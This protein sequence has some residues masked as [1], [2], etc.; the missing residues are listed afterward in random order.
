MKINQ[1]KSKVILFNPCKSI[2]FMTQINLENYGLE[3]FE[4][5]LLLGLVLRSEMDHQHGLY[6]KQGKLETL[7]TQKG[8]VPGS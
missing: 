8:E 7:D 2:D 1:K 6:D 5:M 3:D 4:E